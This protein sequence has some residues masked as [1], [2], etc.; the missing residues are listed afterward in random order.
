MIE[1]VANKG[2]TNKDQDNI[3]LS[4]GDWLILGEQ[5]GLKQIRMDTRMFLS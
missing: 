5:A 2:K 3:Y 1:F 4:M